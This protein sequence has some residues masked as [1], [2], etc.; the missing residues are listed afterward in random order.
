[1]ITRISGSSMWVLV[2]CVINVD[3]GLCYV[4]HPI[5]R[6]YIYRNGGS[7]I[8]Q[9]LGNE[10]V[11]MTRRNIFWQKKEQEQEQEFTH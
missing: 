11:Y 7:G 5:E 3:F 6:A 1:M 9:S 10:S 2:T 8:S 4:G